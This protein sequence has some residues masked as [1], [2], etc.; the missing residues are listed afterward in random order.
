MRRILAAALLA[1]L[2]PG[3]EGFDIVGPPATGI[4][5]RPPM[6]SPSGERLPCGGG[7]QRELFHSRMST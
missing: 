6:N 7:G 1:A 5:P 2:L 3:C 4:G